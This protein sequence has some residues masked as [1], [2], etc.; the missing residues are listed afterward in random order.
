MLVRLSFAKLAIGINMTAW[1]CLGS[2]ELNF[3]IFRSNFFAPNPYLGLLS[4][5]LG[6]DG[7]FHLVADATTEN[8]SQIPP[9]HP[10]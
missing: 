7:R 8:H 5:V 1:N 10:L 9:T 2:Q 6:R 3:F 4:F